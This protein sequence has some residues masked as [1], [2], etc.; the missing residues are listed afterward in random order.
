MTHLCLQF[1]MGRLRLD[2]SRLVVRRSAWMESSDDRLRLSLVE[3][4]YLS[5][6]NG[7]LVFNIPQKL[8]EV[9]IEFPTESFRLKT[10]LS[11]LM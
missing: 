4:P 5:L 6:F 3:M 10:R 8:S 1:R 2:S 9:A 11:T 7:V